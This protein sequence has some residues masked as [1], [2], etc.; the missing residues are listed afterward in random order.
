MRQIVLREKHTEVTDGRIDALADERL[1]LRAE[2]RVTVA[3]CQ[4]VERRLLRSG[5]DERIELRDDA[6]DDRLRHRVARTQA[7][8]QV[9]RLH[10][11]KRGQRA[12]ALQCLRP[13]RRRAHRLQLGDQREAHLPADEVAQLPKLALAHAQL[14]AGLQHFLEHGTRRIGRCVE[15]RRR[16]ARELGADGVLA[17]LQRADG[18]RRAIRKARMIR[19][20]QTRE[21]GDRRDRS[22]P[23]A[24]RAGSRAR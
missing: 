7:G 22:S 8:S 10:G 9:R 18:A 21:V 4:R 5:C 14:A 17:A 16:H 2:L 12:P 1:Q 6:I 23:A 15:A 11:E 24:P 19:C 20:W 13:Q 3:C